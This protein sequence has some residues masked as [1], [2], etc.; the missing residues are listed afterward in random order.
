MEYSEL[1]NL[2]N[3]CENSPCNVELNF[4]DGMGTI[5]KLILLSDNVFSLNGIIFTGDDIYK[6]DNFSIWMV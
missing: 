6:I 2:A 3:T 1:L 5:G 4:S